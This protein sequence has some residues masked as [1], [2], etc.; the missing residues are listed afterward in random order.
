MFLVA[1]EEKEH[2]HG[3][4]GPTFKR[5]LNHIYGVGMAPCP[6]PQ[7]FS[8]PP[9]GLPGL[10]FQQSRPGTLVELQRRGNLGALGSG[11][12]GWLPVLT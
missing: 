2:F 1:D 9:Q 7:G 5:K 3:A 11:G 10:V 12:Q 6:S 8:S 4:R